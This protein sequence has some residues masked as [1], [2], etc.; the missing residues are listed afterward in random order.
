M[1]WPDDRQGRRRAV[2]VAV[3]GG[4]A[5]GAGMVLR[6]DPEARTCRR[7]AT[8]VRDSDGV[9]YQGPIGAGGGRRL[10]GQGDADHGNRHGGGGGFA[11]EESPMFAEKRDF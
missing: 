4:L 7:R 8:L 1:V 3:V 9:E 2:L 6:G 10:A 5:G 11:L